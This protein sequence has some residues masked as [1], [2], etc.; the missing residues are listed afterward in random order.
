MLGNQF[1]NR[2]NQLVW[3]FHDRLALIFKSG[4]ILR[5]RFLFRLRFVV[6]QYP[7]DSLLIPACWEPTLPHRVP[8]L[9]LR[10]RGYAAN[11][12]PLR[13]YA[14]ITKTLLGSGSGT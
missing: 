11:G 1:A 6:R 5:H 3:D 7:S 13:A 12:V 8:R 14:V 2:L 10:R 9:L 4:L